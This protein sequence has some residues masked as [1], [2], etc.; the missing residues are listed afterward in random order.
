MAA[1]GE[2]NQPFVY[3]IT[4]AHTFAYKKSAQENRTSRRKSR[5]KHPIDSFFACSSS[6]F[7]Y[8]TSLTSIL[9]IRCDFGRARVSP[10][11]ILSLY[12][13]VHSIVR[14]HLKCFTITRME[15]FFSISSRANSDSGRKSIA[16]Y[17]NVL[18]WSAEVRVRV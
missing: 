17:K 4:S 5:L 9:L 1:H 16:C 11:V 18:K 13:Y 7:F 10:A 2:G 3:V 12:L 15:S 14:H 6:F 8:L